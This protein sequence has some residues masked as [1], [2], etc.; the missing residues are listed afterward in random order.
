MLSQAMLSQCTAALFLAWEPQTYFFSFFFL[1]TTRLRIAGLI[2]EISTR[3][4]IYIEEKISGNFFIYLPK[5]S[6][7]YRTLLF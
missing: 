4:F 6:K 3:G 7:I 5:Q 1:R 2:D